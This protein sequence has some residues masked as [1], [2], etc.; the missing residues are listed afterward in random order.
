MKVPFIIFADIESLLEKIDTYQS[1]LEKSSTIKINI[2]LLLLV[3]HYFHIG[4]LITQ[5]QT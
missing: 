1:N 3:I 2:L 4:H 5:K